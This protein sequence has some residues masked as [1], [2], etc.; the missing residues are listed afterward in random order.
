MAHIFMGFQALSP[1][2]QQDVIIALALA[3]L[4]LVLPMLLVMRAAH[5]TAQK[6]HLLEQECVSKKLSSPPPA[7]AEVKTAR[8]K[9]RKVRKHGKTSMGRHS[10]QDGPADGG[11]Q[12]LS[13]S[14]DAGAALEAAWSGSEAADATLNNRLYAVSVGVASSESMAALVLPASVSQA[15]LQQA[16]TNELPGV[17]EHQQPDE[18]HAEVQDCWQPSIWRNGIGRQLTT[19][20]VEQNIQTSVVPSCPPGLMPL[21]EAEPQCKAEQTAKY[22]AEWGCIAERRYG[23]MLLL[24]HKEIRAE[25]LQRCP[26]G[27][28]PLPCPTVAMAQ[29]SM[30]LKGLSTRRL[31]FRP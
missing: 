15:E 12:E 16:E 4:A 24:L 23:H 7:G 1:S 2:L 31:T 25:T 29:E 6:G 26:P 5:E 11:Q 30:P 8:R 20:G 14:D 28:G 3:I 18:F 22:G 13:D 17:V 21:Q 10:G 9:K 19:F 27:L